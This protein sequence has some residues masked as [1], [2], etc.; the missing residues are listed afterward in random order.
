MSATHSR[1]AGCDQRTPSTSFPQ[2]QRSFSTL[3]ASPP[4]GSKSVRSSTSSP[5]YAVTR[6]RPP[7]R[8]PTDAPPCR[9]V[10]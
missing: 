8:V 3:P 2:F 10:R 7:P 4:G 6:T 9:S 1:P 5:V